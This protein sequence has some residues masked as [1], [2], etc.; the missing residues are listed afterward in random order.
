MTPEGRVVV[1]PRTDGDIATPMAWRTG[2]VP[3]GP[4]AFGDFDGDGARDLWLADAEGRLLVSNPAD[5]PY[6]PVDT[7]DSGR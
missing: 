7:A 1:V 4:A 6:V 5:A 3:V 2:R